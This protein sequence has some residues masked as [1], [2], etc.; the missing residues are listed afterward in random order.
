MK[1][2][3]KSDNKVIFVN[4]NMLLP[5]SEMVVDESVIKNP[6]VYAL[7][8]KGLLVVD[9][10][11]SVKPVAPKSAEPVSPVVEE[12]AETVAE[13]ESEV[14]PVARRGRRPKTTEETPNE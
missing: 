11:D 3:N 9:K 5:D 14:A 13:A 7:I 4:H 1:I 6:S 2:V 10:S 12:V 8:Q